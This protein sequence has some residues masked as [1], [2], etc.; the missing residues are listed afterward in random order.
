MNKMDST[1][2]QDIQQDED[3]Y[4]NQNIHHDQDIQQVR[5]IQQDQQLFISSSLKSHLTIS[6]QVSLRE[7]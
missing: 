5:N 2:Y 7:Y 1:E 6:C 4:Q 3:I